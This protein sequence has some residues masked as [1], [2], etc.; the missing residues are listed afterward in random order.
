MT[1]IGKREKKKDNEEQND[2]IEY[3][4]LEKIS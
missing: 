2:D 4:D 1:F 3:T